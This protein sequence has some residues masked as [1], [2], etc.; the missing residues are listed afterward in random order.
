MFDNDQHHNASD[1]LTLCG[2]LTT[3]FSLDAG[4]GP[5]RSAQSSLVFGK[6][7]ELVLC[8]LGQSGD[9]YFFFF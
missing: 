9:R 6:H 7:S 2:N 8:G 1:S 4:G 3:Q 5:P